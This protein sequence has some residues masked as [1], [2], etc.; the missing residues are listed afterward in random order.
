MER[1]ELGD[2]VLSLE[3]R[4][5]GTPTLLLHGLGS[6]ADDWDLVTPA[7]E[8]RRL[9]IPDLR[10]HGRSSKPA[11][12]YGVPRMANDV[13]KLCE[14]VADGPVHVVG[15]S[16]GGMIGLQLAVDRPELLRSLTIINS[17]PEVVARTWAQ[18][19]S[20]AFRLVVLTL[21]GPRAFA[22]IIAKKLFPKPEQEALRER[23]RRTI[24]ANDPIAYGAATR[25]LLGWTVTERLAEI[26]CPVL[27]LASESDYTPMSVKRE[28]TSKMPMA[29]LVEVT[30]SGHASPLDQPERI[31]HEVRA[32][33]EEAERSG[34]TSV[35]SSAA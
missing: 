5:T 4:G 6:C 31:G 35:A 30:D 28:Y 26:R 7:L 9:L 29:R 17:G 34:G 32:F 23:T 12:G 14:R 16:M 11:T 15:V 1:I 19:F 24:G 25:G 33:L 2:V 27:V 22:S 18:R 8:D 3:D 10:G 21:F 20:F 13:A